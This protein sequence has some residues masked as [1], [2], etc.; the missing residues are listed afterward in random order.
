MEQGER[1]VAIATPTV[2][3]NDAKIPI[4]SRPEA[5]VKK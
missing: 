5:R 1:A 4:H 2:R 3:K